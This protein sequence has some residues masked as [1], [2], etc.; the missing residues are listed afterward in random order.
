MNLFVPSASQQTML[1]RILGQDLL[2]KLYTNDKTP[3]LGDLA[4]DYTEMV[5]LGYAAKTLTVGNWSYILGAPTKAIYPQQIWTFQAGGPIK[6]Y[7]YYVVQASDGKLLWA[8]RF[9]PAGSLPIDYFVEQNEG[10]Q[11]VLGSVA[12]P[13]QCTLGNVS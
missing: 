12:Y 5:G 1:E 9:L 7:G 3:A 13:I 11:I 4:A 2:L 6:V 8:E 10:D